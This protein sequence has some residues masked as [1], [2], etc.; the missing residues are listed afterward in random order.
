VLIG[1]GH[2][3][4]DQQ[5]RREQLRLDEGAH[6]SVECIYPTPGLSYSDRVTIDEIETFVS[7]ARLAV[8]KAGATKRAGRPRALR[9]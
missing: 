4:L 2:H 3:D 5:A 9:P 8:I 7:I 1:R 6:T